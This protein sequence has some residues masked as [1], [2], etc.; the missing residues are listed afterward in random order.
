[1][2]IIAYI[3]FA[4]QILSMAGQAMHGGI[5]YMLMVMFRGGIPGFIGFMLPT[6]VGIILLV[7]HNKR[8]SRKNAGTS[9]SLAGDPTAW[10]CAKCGTLNSG[11]VQTCQ[12]C[13]VSRQGS[14]DKT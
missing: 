13:G 12:S 8:Q 5:G 2:K 3:L 6:I 7:N 11:K 1:M 9:D 10:C 4:L 14:G